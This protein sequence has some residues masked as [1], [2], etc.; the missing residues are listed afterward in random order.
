MLKDVFYLTTQN[1]FIWLSSI[2]LLFL[3]YLGKVSPMTILFVYFIE[4]LIIGVFNA[5]KMFWSIKYGK[6]KGYGLILFFIVHYGFFIAIQSIFAFGIFDIDKHSIFRDPINLIEN[7]GIILKL[8]DISYALPA[9]LFTHAGKFFSDF[10]SNK[11]YL[12]FTAK[13]IMFKPYVR[14]IVQ[15][16]AVI[17]SIF[18]IIFS[19]AGLFAAILLIIIRLLIDLVMESIKENSKMVDYFAEKLATDKVSKEETKKQLQIF[20]E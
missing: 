2:Y 15:Q 8:E 20:T 7:Y 1:S 5:L 18:F 14:I 19:K 9:I 6:S 12:L 10:I 11:K 17:L 13:E 16:F 4:T 3:L